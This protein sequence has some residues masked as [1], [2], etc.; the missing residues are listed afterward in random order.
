M[1]AVSI[2]TAGFFCAMENSLDSRIF[3]VFWEVELAIGQA[4]YSS[5]GFKKK[6]MS[7]NR[8]ELRRN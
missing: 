5:G 7:C 2:G 1:P 8:Q 6:L 4:R 3:F